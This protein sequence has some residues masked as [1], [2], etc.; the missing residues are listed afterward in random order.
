MAL[1]HPS[2]INEYMPTESEREAY[3]L[4]K[5]NLSDDFECFYSVS[6]SQMKNGT[7]IKSEADFVIMH[8]SYGFL[9]LEVKGGS[10]IV[11]EDGKWKLL[12][13]HYGTR[14]LPRSPYLQAEES[15][16]YFKNL[17]EST[18]HRHYS[19]IFA[20]GVFFPFYELEDSVIQTISD[21]NAI[22][23]IDHSSIGVLEERIHKMFKAWAGK[24]YGRRIYNISEHKFFLGLIKKRI[25]ISAAAG[26]L[27]P[28]KEQQLAT[29]NRVQD[30]YV[31]LLTNINRFYIK[32]GA[33]TGKTWIAI[34]MAIQAATE[35][36]ETLIV[37]SSPYL[38]HYI[39]GIVGQ[40][41]ITV[42]HVKELF[43]SICDERGFLEKPMYS[44]VLGCLKESYKKYEAIYVDEA[45]DFTEEWATVIQKLLLDNSSRLGVF[46]DDSQVFRNDSFGDG[47]GIKS[48]PYL[49]R[50]NIRNTRSIYQWASSDTSIGLE[51]VT[52]PIEGPSPS[53]EE[54][55]DIPHLS[56]RLEAFLKE[57]LVDEK[58]GNHSIVV[59]FDT[60]D[61]EEYYLRSGIAYWHFTN[62]Q[63]ENENDVF[64]STVENYKGLEANMVIYICDKN[65]DDKTNYIAYTRAKY[66]LIV[67]RIKGE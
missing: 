18:F 27:I 42:M 55:L 63:I 40:Y 41:A 44:G 32:G 37:C 49:L 39:G 23:T 46:Y 50:E 17:Y 19:G 25:A 34:K 6:W 20:A 26:A 67:L 65:C 35:G 36:K 2:N 59:L 9:C 15:M 54:V 33:G 1:M 62:K 64:V 21:R 10:G 13:H 7:L 58:V 5:T 11:I 51:V 30:N 57:Y 24:S 48:E 22:C 47:F 61:K 12:D 28:F 45:Q 4:L 16:Y 60:A 52:N 29:I 3:F 38:S 31:Y 14:I 8:P 53:V 56:Q 66:Y 43:E